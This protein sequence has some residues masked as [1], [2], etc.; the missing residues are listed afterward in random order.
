MGDDGH[1]YKIYS[2][3][4][5]AGMKE[6]SKHADLITP[7]LTEACLLSDIP[8]DDFFSLTS[9]DLIL[10]KV[11][12]I[13]RILRERAYGNQDV[14]ITGVK[15]FEENQWIIYNVALT[16]HGFSL[17]PLNYFEKSLYKYSR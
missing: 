9:K 6:L 2:D 5:L 10:E 3:G 4:L 14:I 13:A 1:T 7:N 16:E 11:F 17:S 12:S 15:I 8:Y